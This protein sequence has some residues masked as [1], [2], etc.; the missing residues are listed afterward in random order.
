M[1]RMVLEVNHHKGEMDLLCP[2]VFCDQCNQR[3]EG[4]G[5]VL[6]LADRQGPVTGEMF[7]L[8]KECN[9]TFERLNPG[10][11]GQSYYWM[12]LK[13]LPI[14]LAANLGFGDTWRQIVATIRRRRLKWE[15]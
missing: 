14:Q 3:I 13:D 1:I 7:H 9:R 15:S 11:E 10:A 4:F 12:E 5:T 8:H 6:Y 2:Q